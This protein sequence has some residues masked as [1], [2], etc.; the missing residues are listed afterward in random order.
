MKQ[1]HKTDI[2]CALARAD[3]LDNRSKARL[4]DEKASQIAMAAKLSIEQIA[5]LNCSIATAI[6][7]AR[8]LTKQCDRLMS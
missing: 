5:F 8:K 3:W 6:K 7:Q 1:L 4:T 2:L